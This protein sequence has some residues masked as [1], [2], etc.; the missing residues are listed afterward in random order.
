MNK[1]RIRVGNLEVIAFV[2]G[3]VL[4]V[5]ELAGARILAPSIGSSTYVWTSVIGVIIMALSIG[6]WLGGKLADK[7]GHAVD[8]AW[9]SLLTGLT[10]AITVLMYE[11][12]TIW[13]I[14]ASNDPRIQGVLASLFLFAPTSV[15]LGMKS[16]YLA[17]LKVRSLTTTG[18]SVASLSALNSI[19]GIVGTFTAGFIL[20]GLIGSRETFLI[21][22]MATIAISWLVVPRWRWKLRAF[23]SVGILLT[24][25]LPIQQAAALQIDTPSA[26]YTIEDRGDTRYLATGP[27]AAQS[28]ISLP[29]PDKLVFWYTQQLAQLVEQAPHKDRILILGGGAFTLPQHLAQK[30]PDSTIDTVEIDPELAVIARKYF[31]Y[32]DPSNVNLIFEDAR[33]YVNQTDKQ[34]DIVLVDV[35]GDSQVPFT[36]L[37]A[38]YGERIAR[39]TAPGGVVGV[40]A[41]A[42]HEGDCKVLLDA[43]D[44]PYR[45]HFAYAG[46]VTQN[47]QKD[48]SNMVIAYSR[49]P[50]EWQGLNHFVAGPSPGYTDNFAP[51]ERLQHDCR[52]R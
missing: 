29:H 22:I 37:S 34:Y 40:N 48:R 36:L 17:K 4:M 9:L 24:V 8:L 19:G 46:Y 28:G 47:P 18:Q 2:S 25:L 31:H 42:G 20:F 16:P 10:M 50:R 23:M 30:Y 43:I 7:R 21:I 32:S 12:V 51:A 52:Q 13:V 49:E 35:Y 14:E 1:F 45:S 6:Y 38:E 27:R 39:I 44:A 3:F 33:I 11:D 41:I 5:F 26:R 15:L